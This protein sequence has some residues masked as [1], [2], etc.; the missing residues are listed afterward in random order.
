MAPKKAKL[1]EE[2]HAKVKGIFDE[3]KSKG[4]LKENPSEAPPGKARKRAKQTEEPAARPPA[5]SEGSSSSTGKAALE[6]AFGLG[7]LGRHR[8]T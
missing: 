7:S 3:L 5:E 8:G 1:S 4:L 6:N 2:A